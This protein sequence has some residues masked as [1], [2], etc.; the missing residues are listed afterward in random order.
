[1]SIP[2]PCWV[3]FQLPGLGRAP[4][5]PATGQG[6]VRALVQAGR[7]ARGGGKEPAW[8]LPRGR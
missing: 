3:G 1:M 6:R 2:H 5:V 4:G 8:L 7:L